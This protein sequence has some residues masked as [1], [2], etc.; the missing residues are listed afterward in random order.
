MNNVEGDDMDIEKSKGMVDIDRETRM[1][2][3]DQ[4]RR[5][6]GG[7]GR[8]KGRGRKGVRALGGWS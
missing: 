5:V 8:G 3:K 6:Y 2:V 1:G 7:E 4:R